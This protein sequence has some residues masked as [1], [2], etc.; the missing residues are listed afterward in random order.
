[1]HQEVAGSSTWRE[2]RGERGRL[3][4]GTRGC[5][6]TAPALCSPS[7]LRPRGG[8]GKWQKH[9]SRLGRGSLLQPRLCGSV[10]SVAPSRSPSRSGSPSTDSTS[11]RAPEK[12]KTRSAAP[13][14]EKR[15][16]SA[17]PAG[18]VNGVSRSVGHAGARPTSRTPSSACTAAPRLYLS[19]APRLYLSAVPR[20]YLSAVPRLPLGRLSAASRHVPRLSL[21]CLSA[22]SRLHLGCT[23]ATSRLHLA[24][25]SAT[26][27][28]RAHAPSPRRRTRIAPTQCSSRRLRRGD[29]SW[30]CPGR[31]LELSWTCPAQ[32]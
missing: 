14:T 2:R 28:R 5:R 21:G 22:V 13:A 7:D 10:K 30:T 16:A 23:S 6:G 8:R 9:P 19:A 4:G 12:R 18:H 31:V 29:V 26:S 32:V 20:L 27:R 24:Y 3:D 17:P 1:M 25:I 15:K 11:H